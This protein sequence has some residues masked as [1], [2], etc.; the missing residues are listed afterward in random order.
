[1]K[2]SNGRTISIGDRVK[3]LWNFDNKHHTGRI[4]EIKENIVT[5]T[6][7]GTRISTTTNSRITKILNQSY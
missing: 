3:I 4:V 6:T 2:D 5:I 1:M 7:S